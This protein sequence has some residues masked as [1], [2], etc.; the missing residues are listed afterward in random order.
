MVDQPESKAWLVHEVVA[1]IGEPERSRL[2][3]AAS[4]S[5]RGFL[6]D[7]PRGRDAW[8]SLSLLID[9][10]VLADRVAGKGDLQLAW[11]LGLRIAR[12]EVGP[13]QE[14]ALRVVRPSMLMSVAPGLF[15]THFRNCGRVAIRPSGEHSLT[16]SFTGLSTPHRAHCKALGGW[17]EGWLGIGR[18]HSI[19]V[20]H[21][22]CRCDGASACD[23]T[24]MWAV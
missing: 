5:L 9:A 22:T 18:R 16:A 23:Y 19:R 12:N 10:L 8:A 4:P 1:L 24:A 21:V 7:G 20:E 13:V 3:E 17:M 2:L 6:M 11:Q 14:I 15:G